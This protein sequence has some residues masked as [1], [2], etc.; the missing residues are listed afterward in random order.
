MVRCWVVSMTATLGTEPERML[1]IPGSTLE[2][3]VD[4][5]DAAQ[6]LLELLTLLGS[7]PSWTAPELA[8]RLTPADASGLR[9]TDEVLAAWDAQAREQGLPP[10]WRLPARSRRISRSFASS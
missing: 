9:L 6:R 2:E 4:V 8:G 7:R 1:P 5:A 10:D 3:F